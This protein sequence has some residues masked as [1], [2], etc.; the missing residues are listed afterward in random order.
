MLKGRPQ[1]RQRP[2]LSLGAVQPSK[3]EL[4]RTRSPRARAR[5]KHRAVQRLAIL[6]PDENAD[7]EC[8]VQAEHSG[9]ASSY[10]DCSN[11]VLGGAVAE[12]RLE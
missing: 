11:R 1:A 5:F 4:G 2:E 10:P 9:P 6:L 7:P 8:E 12:P 3:A